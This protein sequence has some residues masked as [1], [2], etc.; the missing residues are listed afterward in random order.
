MELR[1]T[2]S[3]SELISNSQRQHRE[4][5]SPGF[6]LTVRPQLLQRVDDIVAREREVDRKLKEL[7]VREQAIADAL[8]VAER[9]KAEVLLSHLDDAYACSLC[10]EIMAYPLVFVTRACGHTFCAGC[11]IRWFLARLHDCA[12]W[13][14]EL[15]CPVCRAPQISTCSYADPQCADEGYPCI[16]VGYPYAP[17]RQTATALDDIMDRLTE[18]VNKLG[19]AAGEDLAKW[20]TKGLARQE[21]EQRKTTGRHEAA[22]FERGWHERRFG[23]LLSL[24]RQLGV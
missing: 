13:H 15:D 8:A 9:R 20:G 3:T 6:K 21:W 1:G 18:S 16:H 7:A 2:P 19:D 17:N 22:R 10:Y 5:S 11:L 4:E 14:E 24:K 12:H 23:L